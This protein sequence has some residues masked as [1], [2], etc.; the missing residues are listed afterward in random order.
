MKALLLLGLAKPN[1]PLPGMGPMSFAM[2]ER[3]VFLV[4]IVFVLAVLTTGTL[5]LRRHKRLRSKRHKHSLHRRIATAAT[6]LKQILL[7]AIV[8]VVTGGMS[9]LRR[10]K[11]R[12]AKRHEHS[13]H[14]SPFSR[15]TAVA[16]ELEQMIRENQ[17][18]R[19]RARR[20]RNPTLAETGG[21]PPRHSDDPGEPLSTRT[22]P[23]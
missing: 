22:Q 18:R 4:A 1:I 17:R 19:C 3:R 2:Q 15:A 11:R 13:R 5:L 6:E 21:L 23:Q 14:R 12:Y 9:L 16:T 8:L 10:L 7:V 20:P